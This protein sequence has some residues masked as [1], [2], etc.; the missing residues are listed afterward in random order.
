MMSYSSDG[1]NPACPTA[2]HLHAGL[3]EA[4][5]QYRLRRHQLL[6]TNR[7]GP[8]EDATDQAN[9]HA[10][11]LSRTLTAVWSRWEAVTEFHDQRRL[12]MK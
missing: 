12:A 2:M 4:V 5:E 10:N 7:L 9:L 8:V 3:A 6:R 1:W 11:R